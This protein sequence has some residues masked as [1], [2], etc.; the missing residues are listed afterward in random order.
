MHPTDIYKAIETI[1]A[2]C[3]AFESNYYP[4]MKK[5]FTQPEHLEML[6]DDKTLI[7]D[8]RESSKHIHELVES[9]SFRREYSS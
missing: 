7:R 2:V 8:I 9:I 1:E 3:S 5:T 6:N 4:K